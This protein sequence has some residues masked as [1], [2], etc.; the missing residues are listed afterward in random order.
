MTVSLR[1]VEVSAFN[2]V[3]VG[4]ASGLKVG[5]L[6]VTAGV[7]ALRPGQEVRLLGAPAPAA[8]EESGS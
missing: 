1:P 5:E 4:I 8:T 3:S 7:Q 2:P 6:V